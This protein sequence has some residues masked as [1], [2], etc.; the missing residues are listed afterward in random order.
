MACMVPLRSELY[1]LVESDKLP[2]VGEAI[3]PIRKLYNV[4]TTARF[5]T[6]H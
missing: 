5:L 3:V 4:E 6:P 1:K 2:L